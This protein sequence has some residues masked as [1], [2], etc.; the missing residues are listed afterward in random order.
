[1]LS[2]KK[3]ANGLIVGT[4][5]VA[6]AALLWSLDGT[7]LRPE[8]FSIPPVL[9]V[10]LEHA[11]GFL[12]LAPLLFL[13]RRDLK[14]I[15]K[16]TWVAIGYVALFGGALGTLFFTKALFLTGFT[17]ISVVILLQKFQPVFALLLAALFLRERFPKGFYLYAAL[18]LVA[19]YFVTFKDFA[20]LSSLFSTASM[21]ALFSL[22]AAFAWGSST[23]FGK[24]S[25]RGIDPGLLASLRFGTTAL[26]LVFPMLFFAGPSALGAIQITEWGLFILIALT[27]GSGAMFL[28]YFGLK[29]IPASL[30][31]IAELAWPV[32]AIF[33]DFLA[34]GNMLSLSQLAGAFVLIASVAR[35]TYLMRTRTIVA[36]VIEGMGKGKKLGIATANLDVSCAGDLP[37]GLYTAKALL[38]DGRRFHGL[39]YYGWNSL[40]GADTLEVHLQGFSGDLYGTQ[41]RVEAERYLRLPKKF[42]SVEALVAQIKE[43]VRGATQGKDIA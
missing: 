43:D 33:F 4:C 18:A 27:S 17:D 15:S 40:K 3:Y 38:P 42:D 1:M 24:Y 9:V 19:G 20:A 39:L 28:Y 5:A 29:K 34:H 6:S 8:L 37:Q 31:T 7:F 30:A 36:R 13:H 11:V 23:V 25:L 22:L 32:S 41:L 2:P 16:K 10:F 26:L 35:L 14:K 12:V 21:V